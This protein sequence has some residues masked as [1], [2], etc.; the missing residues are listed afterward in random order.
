MEK[1]SDRLAMP[2]GGYHQHQAVL[3]GL[4][5]QMIAGLADEIGVSPA[6]VAQWIGV[7]ASSSSLT[8]LEGEAL[9]RLVNVL[10]QLLEIQS[11]NVAAAIQWL[12]SPH[13][14]LEGQHPISLLKTESGGRAVRQLLYAIEYGLPV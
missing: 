13:V 8:A 4:P 3:A 7:K 6:Q 10:D 11:G 2:K 14:L 1:L 12:S 9:L 5:Y